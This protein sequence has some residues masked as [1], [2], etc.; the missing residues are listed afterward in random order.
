MD[1]SHNIDFK[2]LSDQ[3]RAKWL[4]ER[5]LQDNPSQETLAAEAGV[6][7]S[8]I[9]RCRRSTEYYKLMMNDMFADSLTIVH[10]VIRN[11]LAKEAKGKLSTAK[12]YLEICVKSGYL[13][14][15]IPVADSDNKFQELTDRLAGE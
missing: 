3:D 6:D 2:S 14:A 13:A 5:L 8:T 1:E 9:S 11:G 15:L 4:F 10:R 12:W 7:Q